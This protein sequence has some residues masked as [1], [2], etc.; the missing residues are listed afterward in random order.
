MS[1]KVSN[2]AENPAFNKG[3]VMYSTLGM[4]L[5]LSNRDIPFLAKEQF[6][7]MKK[8]ILKKY[9]SFIGYEIQH[10]KK[11]CYSC[12][13]TGVFKCDWKMPEKCWACCGSG[14]YQEFWTRLEKYKLGKYY[15]HNLVKRQYNY[16]PLFEGEALPIIEGYISHKSPKYRLGREAALW[17]FLFFDRKTFVKEIARVGCPTHKRTPL[18]IIGNLMWLVRNFDIKD[19]LPKKKVKYDYSYDADELPF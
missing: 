17:L 5:H 3:A 18:V 2:E 10:I 7:A 9:G 6:Y 8:R 1:E 15:F 14:V 19:C 4:L 16:E 12:D 13:S 11:E